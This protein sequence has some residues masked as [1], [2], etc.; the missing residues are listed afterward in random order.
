MTNYR[1]RPKSNNFTPVV[2]HLINEQIKHPEVRVITDEGEMVGVL[3]LS[4]ALKI[5]YDGDMDLIEINPKATPPVCKLQDYSKFKYQLSKLE[6]A[7]PPVADKEK[8]LRLSVRIAVNDLLMNARKVDEF[9]D[10]KFKVKIQIRMRGRER[11]HPQL[12]LEVMDQFLEM[13]TQEY[14]FVA[15]PKLVGDS[16]MCTL[17]QSKKKV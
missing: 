16:N 4:E 2:T 14:E 1:R 10:K 6:A 3:K 9:L 7:K 13:L 5:A 17:K 11:S 15:E 8:M 12:A